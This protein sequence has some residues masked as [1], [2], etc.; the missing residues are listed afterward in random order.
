MTVIIIDNYDS[1]THNLYQMVS[2][3]GVTTEVFRNDQITVKEL[4]AHN[5]S[6]II[7]SPGPGHPERQR[8]FGIGHAVI[9]HFC[10]H[11]PILGVCLGHQ[12]IVSH[13]GGSIIQAPTIVHGK[14][15][16]ISHFGHP[17]FDQIPSVFEAMRYHSLVADPTTIPAEFSVTAQTEDGV[18]MGVTHQHY[19]VM[20]VQFHPESIGTPLGGQLL[21]NFLMF[22]GTQG[23]IG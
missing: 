2:A 21:R 3:M 14:S 8:D 12:G 13:W 15:S 19:S 11:I 18:V 5:P 4:A 9:Q 16:P 22:Q 17:L 10:K 6:H 1:F 20:G 23:G 7:L